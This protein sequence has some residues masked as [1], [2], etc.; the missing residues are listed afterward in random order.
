MD[1]L[2]SS[3]ARTYPDCGPL[4]RRPA[5]R[6]CTRNLLLQATGTW[7]EP[8]PDAFGNTRGHLHLEA[9]IDRTQWGMT[10]NMALPSGGNVLDNDVSL[11]VDLSLIEQQG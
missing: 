9:V 2:R 11:T 4:R 8:A 6:S 5:Q 3:S 1:S 7:T 10:W